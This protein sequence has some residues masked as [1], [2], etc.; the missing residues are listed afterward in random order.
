MTDKSTD[1][2]VPDNNRLIAA[3]TEPKKVDDILSAIAKEVKSFVPDLTTAKSRKEITSL[4]FK[5]TRSKTAFDDV[6]KQINAEGRAKLN[7]V[8]AERRKIRDTLDGLAKEVKAPLVE[9]EGKETTRVNAHKA[10]LEQMDISRITA[11][12]TSEN[13]NGILDRITAIQ[14]DDD[15]EEFRVSAK[16]NRTAAIVTLKGYILT[17]VRR[18]KDQLELDQLRADKIKRDQKDRERD[19]AEA[20]EAERKRKDKA[21]KDRKAQ[22]VRD[23]KAAADKATKDA[24]TKA[25]ADADAAEAKH[26]REMAEAKQR[27]EQAA[28]RERDRLAKIESDKAEA[29]EKRANNTRRRNKVKKDISEAMWAAVNAAEPENTK[30]SIRVIATLLMDGKIPHVEVKF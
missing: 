11:F 12:D 4:A 9:W 1:L 22:Q 21:E 28:Q 29:A 6:G 26:K 14:T 30:D 3:F 25:K 5:V 24:E 19:E 23:R 20:A 8:D 13:L 27:E 15:W 16:A 7:A 18:E 10:R 17:A 2:M